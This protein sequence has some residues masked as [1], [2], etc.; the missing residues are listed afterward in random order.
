MRGFEAEARAKRV[1]LERA[2]RRETAARA[3]RARQGRARPLN[4]LTNALRHT[5]SDGTVAVVA[6]ARP[7]TRC[8]SPSRTRAKGSRPRRRGGCSTASGAA[9]RPARGGGAGPRA[10]DRPRPR[11]GAGRPDLGR[12]RAEGRRAGRVHA[13]GRL[14]AIGHY[15]CVRVIAVVAVGCVLAGGAGASARQLRTDGSHPCVNA[16]GFTCSILTVPLDHAGR[17]RWDARVSPSRRADDATAPRGVLLLLTGGPGP[18]GRAGA[19]AD[20][21]HR[22]ALSST[23]YRVVMF[24]QRGTGAA[25]RSTARP[26]QRGDG[27]LRSHAAAGRAPCRACAAA[28][29]EP[30]RSSSATRR[31]RRRHGVAARRRSAST[32][33]ALDGISYGTFVGERYALA[34]TRAR[35]A[36]SCST[37]S[38]RSNGEIDLGARRVPRRSARCFATS[39]AATPA[40]ADLAAA[41]RKTAM[42][43][44]IFDALTLDEHRRSHRSRSTFDVPRPAARGRQRQPGRAPDSS[45]RTATTLGG[46]A[47]R[48]RSTRACTRARS[49][50]T[51]GTRGATR[52]RRSPAATQKLRAAV[53]R[54]PA[55]AL[56]IR[57]TGR[58]RSATASCGSACRGRRL[59]RRRC[60]RSG[61]K[62]RVPALL[63]E[64][65][66]RPVDAARVG[67]QGA[68]AC[69]ARQA[70][71]RARRRALGAVA[72]GQRRRAASARRSS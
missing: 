19:A 18:A 40:P 16:P 72:R 9:T 17:T 7:T 53:A 62:L 63:V 2:D 51:G 67:A 8:R 47:G 24:D 35:V 21:E 38:S 4:L 43:P 60:R 28:A 59:R 33:W 52:R 36:S 66:P 46:V 23:A 48:R 12:D 15:R 29:R 68:R 71:R 69:A 42:A 31:R 64:R 34:H 22:S 26:L 56:S 14:S 5:P 6:R 3:L 25:A 32:R 57:S 58:R 49:V 39:A 27:Q 54:L 70:R 37:R 45:S 41:V 13:A 50:P 20:L 11:R 30:A 61:A 65:R 1:R 10:R 44:A 55:G